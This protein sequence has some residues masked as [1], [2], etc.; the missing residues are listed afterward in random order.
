[1]TAVGD[2]IDVYIRR[3]GEFVEESTAHLIWE[4]S[5]DG[6]PASKALDVAARVVALT[7]QDLAAKADAW[8]DVEPT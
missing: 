8:R 2:A 3:L 6:T 4:F 5:K 1:M 7:A